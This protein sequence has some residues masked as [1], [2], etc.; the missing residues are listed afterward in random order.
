[1]KEI[2]NSRLTSGTWSLTGIKTLLVALELVEPFF[3]DG[4]KSHLV[5]VLVVFGHLFRILLVVSCAL[6][7]TQR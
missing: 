1:M 4:C 5:T 6:P 3:L 7:H 2:I